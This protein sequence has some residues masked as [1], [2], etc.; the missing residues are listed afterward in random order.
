[1]SIFFVENCNLKHL[2]TIQIYTLTNG[3][4]C[5]S[6]FT[7][8]AHYST[9]DNY[10]GTILFTLSFPTSTHTIV[11]SKQSIIHAQQ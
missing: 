6:L 7:C 8:P 10:I 3:L 2:H 1:M 5:G 9:F 4:C 11:K